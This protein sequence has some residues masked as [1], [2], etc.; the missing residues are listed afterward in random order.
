MQA[1]RIPLTMILVGLLYLSQQVV[2]MLFVQDN[3]A[4]FMH[5]IGGV[6]GTVFGFKLKKH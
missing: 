5:I 2:G 6:C 1:G 4:N 3:V